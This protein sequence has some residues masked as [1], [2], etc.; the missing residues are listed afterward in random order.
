MIS[1]R[2]TILTSYKKLSG[3]PW[4]PLVPTFLLFILGKKMLD[5]NDVEFDFRIGHALVI[6]FS[7]FMNNVPLQ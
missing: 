3:A 7:V 4:P 5:Q 1:V 2:T 6:N